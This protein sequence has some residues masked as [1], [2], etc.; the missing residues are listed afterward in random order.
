MTELETKSLL[1]KIA[2]ATYAQEKVFIEDTD[3]M[4]DKDLKDLKQSL[5]FLLEETENT[6]AFVNSAIAKRKRQS[7]WVE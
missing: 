7:S 6:Q 4:T 2:A 1:L 3:A 5:E